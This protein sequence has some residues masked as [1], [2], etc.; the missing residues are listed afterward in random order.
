MNFTKYLMLND[1]IMQ[2]YFISFMEYFK[3]IGDNI[4]RVFNY[5]DKSICSFDP[6]KI[7]SD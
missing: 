3:N 7:A 5:L 1:K 4:Q 2:E 6:L